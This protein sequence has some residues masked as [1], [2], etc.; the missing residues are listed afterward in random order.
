[1]IPPFQVSS[2]PHWIS[3][4]P[5]RQLRADASPA[6]DGSDGDITRIPQLRA[7]FSYPS[8]SFSVIFLLT[9]SGMCRQAIAS[10]LT[11][12]VTGHHPFEYRRR[13][14]RACRTH[15]WT[16]VVGLGKVENGGVFGEGGEGGAR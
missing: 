7:M 6:R 16:W 4:L 12:P 3:L 11:P 1:M 5:L 8:S 9:V 10:R 14:A 13:T 15:C 2:T